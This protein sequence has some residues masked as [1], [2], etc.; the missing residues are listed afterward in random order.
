M[1]TNTA[2]LYCVM[3]KTTKGGLE[4]LVGAVNH[5]SGKKVGCVPQHNVPIVKR[6]LGT[7]GTSAKTL[8]TQEELSGT[9]VQHLVLVLAFIISSLTCSQGIDGH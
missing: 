5:K 7:V 4:C 2:H 6:S 8:D 3:E 1:D 9:H